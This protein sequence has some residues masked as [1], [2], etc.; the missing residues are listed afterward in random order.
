[1]RGR[2]KEKNP[3]T[4]TQ[5][6]WVGGTNLPAKKHMTGKTMHE[7]LKNSE[8]DNILGSTS[9]VIHCTSKKHFINI[10]QTSKS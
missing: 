6:R 7:V 10:V 4:L 9:Q 5:E 1:V 3:F 2:E 8:M